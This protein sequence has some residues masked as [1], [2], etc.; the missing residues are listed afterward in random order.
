MK[1]Y[2]LVRQNFA[3]LGIIPVQ[4]AQP[5]P[6]NQKLWISWLVFGFSSILF[7][8]SLFYNNRNFQEYIEILNM[9]MVATSLFASLVNTV[10]QRKILF[11]HMKNCERIINKSKYIFF[12]GFF[13]PRSYFPEL[14]EHCRAINSSGI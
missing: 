14:F 4:S 11:K 2:R 6:F 10:L 3:V 9:V 13:Y 5:N 12:N 7:Y 1:L 8:V